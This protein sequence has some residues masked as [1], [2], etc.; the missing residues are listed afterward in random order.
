MNIDFSLPLVYA[1]V[2]HIARIIETIIYDGF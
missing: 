2:L 1:L